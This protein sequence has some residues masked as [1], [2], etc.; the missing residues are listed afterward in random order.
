MSGREHVRELIALLTCRGVG[1]TSQEG[2][3]TRSMGFTHIE[4]LAFHGVAQRATVSGEALE[5]R[6][7]RLMRFTLI[8]L[9][10]CQGVA[11]R[12]KRSIRFTLI[13]LL[14]VI[15]IIAI[16]AAMLLP[17]LGRAKETS[18]RSVCASNLRQWGIMA[19]DFGNDHDGYYPKA[20]S[21][22][23][24]EYGIRVPGMLLNDVGGNYGAFGELT[25]S[26]KKKRGTSLQVFAEYGLPK[27][28]FFCPGTRESEYGRE[29]TAT[30]HG[31][32]SPFATIW[33]MYMGGYPDRGADDQ[34]SVA[35]CRRSLTGSPPTAATD[36]SS[37][38]KSTP[39][40]P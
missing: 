23:S 38:P 37:I 16:L 18:L 28:M 1:P 7:K 35:R 36:S 8:E 27:P 9:L 39:R 6:R 13:E 40:K 22:Q 33:Y 3:T 2:G 34:W 30:N 14:V 31:A 12:A 24:G 4:L 17:V 32:W 20:Y 26:D 29:H 19:H 11:R 10:A 21:G 25:G 5:R 15:A